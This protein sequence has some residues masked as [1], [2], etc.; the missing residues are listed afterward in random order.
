MVWSYFIMAV[1]GSGNA[2]A[3]PRTVDLFAGACPPPP[4]A[5]LVT[6]NGSCQNASAVAH[7]TWTAVPGAVSYTV[8]RDGLTEKS[9]LPPSP[10]AYDE[11]ITTGYN[12]GAFVSYA[13]RAVLRGRT[14]TSSSVQGFAECRLPPPVL[15]AA[16]TSCDS[17]TNHAVVHLS[18]TVEPYRSNNTAT[19][20][21]RY[22]DGHNDGQIAAFLSQ[23]TTYDDRT[24]VPGHTYKYTVYIDVGGFPTSNPVSITTCPVLLAPS[25][26]LLTAWSKCNG[27]AAFAH[28]TWSASTGATSYTVLRN[29]SQIGTATLTTFDDTNALPNQTYAYTVRATGTGGSTDSTPSTL[30]IVPCVIPHT[31]LRVSDVTVSPLAAAQGDPIAIGFS[32][33]NIGL[34]DAGPTTTR[35][36]LGSGPDPKAEDVLIASVVTPALAAGATISQ[37]VTAAIPSPA[38]DGTSFVFVSADDAHV[39]DDANNTNNTAR[40]AEL[41]VI[42]APPPR[43]VLSCAASAPKNGMVQQPM[44]MFVVPSCNDLAITWDFGDKT[45]A[46]GTSFLT[47]SYEK[48]GTYRWT[49]RVSSGADVCEKSGSIEI[50][51]PPKRRAATH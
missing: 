18:W 9:E 41:Q 13:I 11:V 32:I 45:T 15:T 16:L 44:F 42:P 7:V 40:S 14:I 10:L 31:D 17:A 50:A 33:S 36:R 4:D 28:L 20:V 34:R 43:C 22:T 35:L 23:A 21:L 19:G 47:H 51:A 46:A 39:T 30:A 2:Y 8:L 37:S 48:A 29:G 49:V 5:P 6:V 38:A 3:P 1:N 12:V 27:A 26:P 25:V 24:A